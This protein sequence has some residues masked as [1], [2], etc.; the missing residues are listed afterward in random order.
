MTHVRLAAPFALLV[1]LGVVV[2]CVGSPTTTL[3]PASRQAQTQAQASGSTPS[4][5]PTPSSSPTPSPT[6]HVGVNPVTDPWPVLGADEVKTLNDALAAANKLEGEQQDKARAKTLAMLIEIL[7][8]HCCNFNQVTQGPSYNPRRSFDGYTFPIAPG[9]IAQEIGRG[10]FERRTTTKHQHEVGGT[11]AWLYSTVKHELVHAQQYQDPTRTGEKSLKEND[12]EAYGREISQAGRTGLSEA[13]LAEVTDRR[14]ALAQ[15]PPAEVQ[16]QAGRLELAITLQ[17][18][19]PL[20][21]PVLVS[22]RLTN[23]DD[24]PLRVNAR[25]ALNAA[26][27][28]EDFR[29]LT[30]VIRAPNGEQVPFGADIRIGSIAAGDVVELGPGQSVE[31][32]V[33]LAA[34]YFLRQ[35]GVYRV[36]ATYRNASSLAVQLGPIESNTLTFTLD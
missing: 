1:V 5:S 24:H 32:S 36:A 13:E 21:S 22:I 4:G 19:V 9:M 7:K 12:R 25:L 6:P 34:N 10:G 29:E 27:V 18:D 16:P 33:D 23:A 20:G 14:D 3:P 2:A 30:F 35:R 28:P 8:R 11:V 17:H 26:I 31:A 15:D